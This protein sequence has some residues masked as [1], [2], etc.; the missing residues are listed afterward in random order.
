MATSTREAIRDYMLDQYGIGRRGIHDGGTVKTPADD[1]EFGGPGGADRI[2]N[3]QELRFTGDVTSSNNQNHIGRIS[4]R[5]LL[6]GGIITIDPPP[7]DDLTNGDTFDLLFGRFRFQEIHDSI[8]YALTQK[9][10][11]RLDLSLSLVTD[12]DMQE[13]AVASWSGNDFSTVSSKS[14]ASFPFG[15][16]ELFVNNSG[17]VGFTHSGAIAVESG[18]DYFLE[19]TVR[20]VS[21]TADLQL[22]DETNDADISLPDA[23]SRSTEGEP[24]ILSIPSVTIPSTCTSV[25][26]RLVGQQNT[27]DTYWSNVQF[28]KNDARHFTLQDLVEADRIGRVFYYTND[29]WHNRGE[30]DR[31][32]IS[33][34]IHQLGSGLWELR[35]NHTVSDRS[36]WYEQFH[37]G[38]ALT[39][40]T[41]T[42]GLPK[43][44]AAAAAT[45]HLLRG[46]AD[47][48]RW[49]PELVKASS[50]WAGYMGQ[51]DEMRTIVDRGVRE[52]VLPRV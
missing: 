10:W 25:T 39:A 31:R 2:Q 36:L 47:D 29:D 26:V 35:L 51:Y 40:D 19:A 20:A 3:G 8:D 46:Y 48:E 30:S 5:P 15:L 43:E 50:D 27:A 23:D 52:F 14:A 42:T 41:S 24:T 37:K 21:G 17:I 11:E 9:L 44:H 45:M 22:H 7:T 4:G 6:A 32:Y 38:L 28:R 49:G 34:T 12:G 16:R 1:S 18:E 13:A 33:H